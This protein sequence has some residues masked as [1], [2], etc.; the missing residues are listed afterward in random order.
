[1][2]H[3]IILLLIL[4][5]SG[6]VYAEKSLDAEL[7]FEDEN[8]ALDEIDQMDVD[9]VEAR[10]IRTREIG[11]AVYL[12][13]AAGLSFLHYDFEEDSGDDISS[14]SIP[15]IANAGYRYGSAY[16]LSTLG[17]TELS[18]GVNAGLVQLAS[19]YIHQHDI[20]LW[21]VPVTLYGKM[22]FNKKIGVQLGV[23]AHYWNLLDTYNP[24][25]AQAKVIFDDSG[26]SYTFTYALSFEH[27]IKRD[28]NLAI[29]LQHYYLPID[30]REDAAVDTYDY[31]VYILTVGLSYFL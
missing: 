1:M 16:E 5:I 17:M 2:K 19:G 27:E 11:S 4:I 15:I 21:S 28:L 13:A 23:G 31:P 22:L 30:V 7:G 20:N 3:Q 29:T 18:W 6:F 12:S 24:A 8:G 9:F 14:I 25:G 10:G 26:I